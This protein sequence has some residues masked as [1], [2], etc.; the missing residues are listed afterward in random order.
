MARVKRR[1]AALSDMESSQAAITASESTGRQRRAS[2]RLVDSGPRDGFALRKT[3][4]DLIVD[5]LMPD[6]SVGPGNATG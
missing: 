2:L 4:R 6:E 3:E 1:R 5:F